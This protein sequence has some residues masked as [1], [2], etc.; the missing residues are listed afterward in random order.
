MFLG[1]FPLPAHCFCVET[2]QSQEQGAF[3]L[4]YLKEVWRCHVSLGSRESQMM[5]PHVTVRS[6]TTLNVEIT[7]IQQP[8]EEPDVISVEDVAIKNSHLMNHSTNWLSLS[9]I[10]LTEADRY[11]VTSGEQLTDNH[12]NFAQCILK[13]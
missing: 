12:I 8:N 5:S 3:Q 2:A 13:K 7:E 6:S 10:K 4:I 9:H 1:R 11:I